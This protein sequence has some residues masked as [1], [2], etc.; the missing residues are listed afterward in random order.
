MPKDREGQLE[1]LL[2]R[3]ERPLDNEREFQPHDQPI[4]LRELLTPRV[5]IPVF[6]Y[7][8]ITLLE[9]SFQAL[10]PLVLAMSV[11]V[12]GLGLSPRTIGYILGSY[13]AVN[14]VFQALFLPRIMRTFGVKRVF[15]CAI[16]AFIPIFLCYPVMNLLARQAGVSGFIFFL[17]ACQLSFLAIVDLGYSEYPIVCPVLPSC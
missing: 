3:T 1:P 5:L 15:V 17:V 8:S 9:T 10:Q 11:E 6:N 4:P 16:L 12:G 7:A 2:A 13:G 14:G